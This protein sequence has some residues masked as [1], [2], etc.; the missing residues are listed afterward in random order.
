[1]NERQAAYQKKIDELI[2]GVGRLEEREVERVLA[3]LERA[4]L[5]VAATVAATDWQAYHIP[6]LKEAVERAMGAYR[7]AHQESQRQANANMW[8]SGIDMIDAPLASAGMAVGAPE[9]SRALL[10]ILQGYSNDLITG[11]AAD[12]VKRINI[13]ISRAVLGQK[14]AH[15]VM[16]AIGLE[17]RGQGIMK[18]IAHRAETIV[19]TEMANVHSLARQARLQATV[20]ANPEI[21]WWKTWHSSGKAHPRMVHANLNGVVVKVDE[22]FAGFI[23]YPHAPGLPAA[24]TVNCGCTHTLTA[25]WEAMTGDWQPAPYQE[26][27]S[28]S[29]DQPIYD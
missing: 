17:L 10:D 22:K 27:A 18:G 16:R 3:L 29:T 23:P 12:A 11:L 14:A 13:E 5:E 4:R 28:Y 26:R 2:A 25:D 7:G 8:E 15:E 24:E 9:I 6:Q 21:D 19:R 20:E 1:M